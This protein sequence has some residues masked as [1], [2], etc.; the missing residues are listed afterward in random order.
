MP[1]ID[2]SG[3]NEGLEAI[4]KDKNRLGDDV[5]MS[6]K[7][8]PI[9]LKKIIKSLLDVFPSKTI[10]NEVI[11][12]NRVRVK[13]ATTSSNLA[14]QD[15]TSGSIYG[16][17]IDVDTRNKLKIIAEKKCNSDPKLI[18]NTNQILN[19]IDRG[20]FSVEKQQTSCGKCSK[21][22]EGGKC[23]YYKRIRM[24]GDVKARIIIPKN[25]E[26]KLINNNLWV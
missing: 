1:E 5:E 12:E 25:F 21:C 23:S 17:I 20:V 9:D 13:L 8:A 3:I 16:E 10:I 14:K 4:P 2:T 19:L 6:A 11:K 7:P 24:Q 22:L 18:N 15:N 26:I